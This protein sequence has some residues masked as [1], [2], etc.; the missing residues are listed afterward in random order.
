MLYVIWQ[1]CSWSLIPSQKSASAV[2]TYTKGTECCTEHL[3][4]YCLTNARMLSRDALAK[5][6]NNVY[7]YTIC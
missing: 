6:S 4:S 2:S 7:T 3:V 1:L 5:G